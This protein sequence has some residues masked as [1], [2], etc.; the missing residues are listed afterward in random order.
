MSTKYKV[1]IVGVLNTRDDYAFNAILLKDGQPVATLEQGGHGG[2]TMM[3]FLDK[4]APAT[5][6]TTDYQDKPHQ[7]GGTV[8]AAEF[9]K[10]CMEHPKWSLSGKTHHYTMEHMADHLFHVAETEKRLAR[11]MKTKICMVDG[12][13]EYTMPLHGRKVDDVLPSLRL[14][15]PKAIILNTLPLEEAVLASINKDK[16]SVG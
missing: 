15:Y 9:A 10:F 5:V 14:Q 11:T 8:E 13:N 4:T 7:Y 6:H 2:P 1:K 16:T 12:R 3:H